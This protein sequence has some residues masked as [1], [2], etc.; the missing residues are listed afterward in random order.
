LRLQQE[1]YYMTN[2]P[3]SISC[4]I[5]IYPP[6]NISR[7]AINVSRALLKRGG[8]F[9]I[10]GKNYYPHI[11]IYMAEFPRRN[12][13]AVE[14]L[15]KKIT[16]GKKPFR[17]E[18]DRYH[19]SRDGYVEIGFK[20]TKAILLLHKNIV[21]SLNPLRDGLMR[22]KDLVRFKQFSKQK[23]KNLKLYGYDNVFAEFAPHMT[24]TK[25]GRTDRRVIGDL[26][27]QNFSFLI[28]EIG[29]FKSAEHGACRK[30]IAQFYLS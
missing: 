16:A 8:L 27:K 19:Q 3:R 26:S 9:A 15:L 12:I 23:Q 25:L 30:I 5:A 13:K 29:L 28:K 2:Q 20:R 11:T 17:I 14:T 1:L 22:P 6:N 4:N 7:R 21:Q 24:F 18:S 10:D